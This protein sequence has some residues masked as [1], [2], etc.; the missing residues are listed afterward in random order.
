MYFYAYFEYDYAEWNVCTADSPD[1]L[2]TGK[3]EI[4]VEPMSSFKCF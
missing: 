4:S 2:V 1:N 3:G